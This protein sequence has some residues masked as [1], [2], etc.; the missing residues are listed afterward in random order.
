MRMR[1][2]GQVAFIRSHSSMQW[3]WKQCVHSGMH[4]ITSFLLYSDRHIEQHPSLGPTPGSLRLSPNTTFTKDSI[5]DS[6]RPILI[7]TSIIPIVMLG[8]GDIVVALLLL[9]HVKNANTIA[10]IIAAPAM[11]N[12]M[13]L[14][15]PTPWCKRPEK[16]KKCWGYF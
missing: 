6:S 7:L 9:K 10:H 13:I 8:C 3:A 15:T 1:R 5:V 12:K 11:D 16:S 14:E 2:W 4:L